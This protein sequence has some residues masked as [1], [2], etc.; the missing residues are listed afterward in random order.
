MNYLLLIKTF[1]AAVKSVEALMPESKGKEKFDAA[2][3]MVEDVIGNVQPL[4][5]ALL[6]VATTVVN[7]LRSVGVFKAKAKAE[8][9]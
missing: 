1:I 8:V 3:A 4:I 6:L 9:Q 2:I 5:P 7:G